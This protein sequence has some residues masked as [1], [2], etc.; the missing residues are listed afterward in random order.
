MA[1]ATIATIV[2]AILLVVR[3]LVRRQIGVDVIAV[4][5]LAGALV[6]RQ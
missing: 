2:P 4:L 5:A 3:S 6:V 1:A